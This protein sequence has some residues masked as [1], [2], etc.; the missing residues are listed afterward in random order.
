MITW[1]KQKNAVVAAV[2]LTDGRQANAVIVG[3]RDNPRGAALVLPA[4]DGSEAEMVLLSQ[5]AALIDA[6]QMV[7][8]ICMQERL[9]GS[10]GLTPPPELA[11]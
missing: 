5:G 1:K 11:E 7:D 4:E 9:H 3:P 6:Q 10:S 2:S 8:I